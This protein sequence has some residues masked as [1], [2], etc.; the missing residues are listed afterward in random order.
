MEQAP[1]VVKGPRI[2]LEDARAYA[3][4][5]AA[6]GRTVQLDGKPATIFAM[7]GN[8]I[9]VRLPRRIL[10]LRAGRPELREIAAWLEAHESGDA[11]LN[12]DKEKR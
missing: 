4:V 12:E 3:R 1:R 2:T 7:M 5:K 9:S 11:T 6:M 8:L 10:D